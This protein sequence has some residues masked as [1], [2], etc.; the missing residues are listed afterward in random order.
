MLPLAVLLP[1]AFALVLPSPSHCT[2][3]TSRLIVNH[4]SIAV[5]VGV[6]CGVGAGEG[7][8]VGTNVGLAV[9]SGEG[10]CEGFAVGSGEGSP[11]SLYGLREKRAISRKFHA[12][13]ALR[14]SH[15][16]PARFTGFNRWWNDGAVGTQ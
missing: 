7:F 11:Q 6:G 16:P 12:A 3:F 10:T 15:T 9:G 14:M 2:S 1:F 5:G 13:D 8:D 4:I